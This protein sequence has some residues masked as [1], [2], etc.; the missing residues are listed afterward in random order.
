MMADILSYFDI[1]ASQLH[2]NGWLDIALDCYLA[3]NLGVVYTGRVFRAFHKPS[4]RKSESYLTF[5]KFGVYSPFSD[6]MS[7]VHCW[8]E[9][10]FYVKIKEG[11]SLGF[12]SFWNPNPL[13]MTGDM[14]ILT[15]SDEVVAE[16]MKKVKADAWTYADALA[17][18]M[19]D[20]PLIRREGEQFIYSKITQFDQEKRRKF[21][22]AE[23]RRKDQAANPAGIVVEP[24][25]K[26]RKPIVT[27]G[28]KLIADAMRSAMP[29]GE[30]EQM[31]KPDLGGYWSAKYGAQGT[32]E[33]E[34]VINDL[35]EALGQLGKVQ[36]NQNQIPGSIHAQKGKT[37]LLTMY[38][39]IRAMEAELLQSVADKATIEKLEKEV[40]DANANIAYANANIASATAALVLR[41]AEIKK[42][43]EKIV[44]D[45]KNYEVAIGEAEYTAGEQAFYYGELLMAYFSLA[46]PEVDFT[47]PQFAVPGPDDVAKYNK[48]PDAKDYLRDYVRRW[49]KG[50]MEESKPPTNVELVELEE[51]PPKAGEE[52]INDNA[53]PL[54]PTSAVEKEV[55]LVGVSEAVEKEASQASA[56]SEKSAKEDAPIIT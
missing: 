6:K 31:V 4:K 19:S 22:E 21:L 30:I 45:A 20:I 3:S 24:P 55:P 14:R 2:P 7:N 40:A 50:S 13:H 43:K 17:F 8:D 15:D 5:A 53:L 33:N 28:P 29:V 27:G 54:G 36:R 46:H 37:E 32:L 49:M 35:D 47:D 44:T 10:F 1:T 18:M 25:L 42:L 23:A 39:R 48:M 52:P 12:P 11:E 9:K 26:R 34:S 38:T 51:V 56:V 16:L 41:D